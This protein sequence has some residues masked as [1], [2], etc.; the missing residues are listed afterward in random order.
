MFYSSNIPPTAVSKRKAERCFKGSLQTALTK[1]GRRPHFLFSSTGMASTGT[2][3]LKQPIL[4]PKL[5]NFY[6]AQY[7]PSK[8]YCS[9]ESDKAVLANLVKDLDVYIRLNSDSY[10]GS[11]NEQGQRH[12]GG[13]MFFLNGDTYEGS[14]LNDAM[15]GKGS[16]HSAVTM[17]TYT[18]MHT[19]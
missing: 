7:H 2:Y 6:F 5:H 19:C 9:N 13:R 8:G 11:R 12:G 10:D 18:R 16:V 14:W 1:Q 3:T 15:T 4:L 17:H